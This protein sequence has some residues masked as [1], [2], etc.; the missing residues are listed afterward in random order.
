MELNIVMDNCTGQNKNRMVLQLAAYLVE[1]RYFHKVN[2]IFYVVG[3]TKTPADCLFNI[4]KATIC[5]SNIY[6]M[7]EFIKACGKHELVTVHPVF[8]EE[9]CN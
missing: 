6:S 8:K 3:H 7:V 5:R 1:L 2:F 4:A 9:F